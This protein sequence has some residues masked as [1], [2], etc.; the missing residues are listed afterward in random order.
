MLSRVQAA[1][2]A[3][4]GDRLQMPPRFSAKRVAGE[5]LYDVARR[6][7]DAEP[8]PMRV[9]ISR[10]E[11]SRF[12]PPEVDFEVECS[13]GTYIRAIA[14]DIGSELG[15][16]AH[17]TALR[18]TRIGTYDIADALRLDDLSSPDVVAR[19]SISPANAIS[20]LQHFTLDTEEATVVLHGGWIPL[21]DGPSSVGPVALLTLQGEL[22][23]IGEVGDDRIYPRK[24]FA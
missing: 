17:L 8:E 7:G 15:V 11:I 3:Q 23:A 22:V 12:Q 24:V 6:G 20:H 19:A 4:L 13:S 14:R 2:E 9:S 18:R 16:G 5:R 1:F 10:I 21:R